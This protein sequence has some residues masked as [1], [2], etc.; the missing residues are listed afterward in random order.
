[1]QAKLTKSKNPKY[2]YTVY[3]S[4]DPQAT[5]RGAFLSAQLNDKKINFGAAG[6][7]DFT[8]HK[9]PIRKK[10]YIKRHQVNEDWTNPLTA[11]WWSR[12]LLWNMPTIKESI[13][14]IKKRFD[15][16]IYIKH[17]D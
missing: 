14:D 1:M 8:T 9:D 4:A 2:K 11:G 17:P 7:E 5:E 15:I 16:K 13:A 6:Y 3:I 12:W 10:R